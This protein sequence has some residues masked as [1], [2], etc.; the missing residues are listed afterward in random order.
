MWYSATARIFQLDRHGRELAANFGHSG[1]RHCLACPPTLLVDACTNACTIL[2]AVQVYIRGVPEP[3][4]CS[5]ITI[6]TSNNEFDSTASLAPFAAPVSRM[7]H[8]ARQVGFS[9]CC[10]IDLSTAFAG[11]FFA[12]AH[13]VLPAVTTTPSIHDE[14]VPYPQI[15]MMSDSG[16]SD[17][18]DNGHHQAA[19]LFLIFLVYTCFALYV[20]TSFLK[21]TSICFFCVNIL[22]V[23]EWRPWR[24]Y[25]GDTQIVTWILTCKYLGA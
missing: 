2:T 14:D 12:S 11:G 9:Y 1:R 7:A 4:T 18:D 16:P 13:S 15:T 17:D 24:R 6:G 5:E 22:G 25:D 21:S 19:A 23:G 3:F 8:L 10:D 20:V